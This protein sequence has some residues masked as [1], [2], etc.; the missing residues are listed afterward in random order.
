MKHMELLRS[1]I[2]K[3]LV[4][5]VLSGVLSFSTMPA[6]AATLKD[7]NSVAPYAKEAVTAL[8]AQNIIAGGS[9]GNFNP[10]GT[11]TRGHMIIMLV[12]AL[13]YDTVNIPSTPTFKDVPATH[14]AYKFVEAAY[15]EGII[16]KGP[17]GKFG[18][19]EN[20]TRQQMAAIFV[21]SLGLKDEQI[22]NQQ[23]LINV[24]NLNDKSKIASWA[25]DHVEFVMSTGLMVGSNGS[26][27]PNTAASRQQAAVVIYRYLNSKVKTTEAARVITAPV[28]YSE[29]YESLKNSM[30][31]YKGELTSNVL[32]QMHNKPTNEDINFNFSINGAVNG[33]NAHMKSKMDFSGTGLPSSIMMYD[34]IVFEKKL[35]LKMADQTKWTLVPAEELSAQDISVVSSD[36][37]TLKYEQ[38]MRSY[39]KLVITNAGT[40]DL[41]G[42]AATKY[43]IT[44]DREAFK[45]FFTALTAQGY[46]DQSTDIENILAN[47]YEGKIEVYLDGQNRIIKDKYSFKANLKL[48]ET[49]DDIDINSIIDNDYTNIGADIEIKAPSLSEVVDTNSG[50]SM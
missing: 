19:N 36:S 13:G 16:T 38:F 27:L 37:S 43:E 29:L 18:I 1:G 33:M 47:P 42:T 46:F 31:G 2:S 23:E 35:F 8:A 6:Q 41:N 48:E 50:D 3:V 45:G 30:L 25:K 22:K 4:G 9:N 11:L 7:M 39:R 26:F 32:L 10:A 24:N 20:C 40:V 34:T 21:R 17:T 12:R 14:W 15:R 5:A 28:Q 49:D 44:L